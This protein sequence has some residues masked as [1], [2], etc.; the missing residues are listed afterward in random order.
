MAKESIIVFCAH[1]DDQI[2]G[3][4]GTIAKYEKDG[5]NVYTI[6]FSYGEGSHFWLKPRVTAEMRVKEA[7]NADKVVGGK[8]VMFL[9]L[10][11]GKFKEEAKES[12]LGNR[13][14]SLI[15]KIKPTRIFTHSKED[16]HPD[17]NAVHDFIMDSIDKMKYK[18]DVYSFNIWNPI[19]IK[20]RDQPKLVVDITDTFKLKI[21]ALKCFKSQKIALYSLLPSVYIKALTN[22]SQ[23]NMRYAEVFLKE[24]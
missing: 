8:N 19:K 18:C 24:R 23:N 14:V 3:A 22:G 10:T 20:K 7:Q 12:K 6:I 1:S 15:K 9:G 2:L 16:P 13:V 4:G 11:E 5:K 17:H 21:K